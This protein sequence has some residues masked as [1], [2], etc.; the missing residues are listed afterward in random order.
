MKKRSHSGHN[1]P[2]L[3]SQ[4]VVVPSTAPST[5][6]S[7]TAILPDVNPDEAKQDTTELQDVNPDEAKQD[8]AEQS[9]ETS[10]EAAPKDYLGLFGFTSMAG[11]KLYAQGCHIMPNF[12]M[13]HSASITNDL[14]S[15]YC[16]HLLEPIKD[17]EWYQDLYDTLREEVR[18]MIDKQLAEGNP[19]TALSAVTPG[20]S[21]DLDDIAEE[22]GLETIDIRDVI[23]NECYALG[24]RKVGLIGTELDADPQGILGSHLAQWYDVKPIQVLTDDDARYGNYAVRGLAHDIAIDRDKMLWSLKDLI[25][26][27]VYVAYEQCDCMVLCNAEL[28][29]LE[30]PIRR[31]FPNMPV[32]NAT[33]LHWEALRKRFGEGVALKLFSRRQ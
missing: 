23:G 31:N 10:P 21:I 15:A 12:C 30:G 26:Q 16:T 5:D 32:I 24:C 2:G 3:E 6:L 29:E 17:S 33:R 18:G 9:G 8:A 13:A 22:Y 4:L 28:E 20:F 7:D 27:A 19:L 1:G 25:L 14:Y 11:V